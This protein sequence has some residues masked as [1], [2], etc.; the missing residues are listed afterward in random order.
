MG[1]HLDTEAASRIEAAAADWFFQSSLDMFV[2]LRANAI[3]R[4]NPAWTQL[5]GWT[6]EDT[7]GRPIR[8]FLHLHDTER[9]RDVGAA[10]RT[11][12]EARSEHRLAR[13]GGGWL[14][15]RSHSKVLADDGLLWLATNQG[16]AWL[17][18]TRSHV[19]TMAPSVRIG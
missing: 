17:D 14:W 8:D 10:L 18:T 11:R 2:I 15:V 7:A 9:L 19:N 4:V 13:K 1:K 3:I 6:P 16:L 5:T 12:G